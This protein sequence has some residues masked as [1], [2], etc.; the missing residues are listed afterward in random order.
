MI[1]VETAEGLAPVGQIAQDLTGKRSSPST[2]WRQ[3]KKGCRGGKLDAVFI[4]GIW[5]TTPAA[6]SDFIRRQTAAALISA[7]IEGPTD[8]ALQA[9]GLL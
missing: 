4:R 2:Y 3:I 6:Y 5:Y 7:P 9:V 1:D 8:T